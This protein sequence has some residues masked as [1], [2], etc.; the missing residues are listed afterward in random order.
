[1]G[2]SYWEEMLLDILEIYT[3]INDYQTFWSKEELYF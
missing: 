3:C 1:M 2:F